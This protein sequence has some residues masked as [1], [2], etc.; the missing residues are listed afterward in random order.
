MKRRYKLMLI[1]FISFLLVIFIYHFFYKPKRIYYFMGERYNNYV[2]YDFNDI[3]QTKLKKYQY[4]HSKELPIIDEYNDAVMNNKD[5]I[6][7]YLK[8]A[9]ILVISLGTYELENY[10]EINQSIIIEY[11]NAVYK[12]FMQVSK[13]QSGSVFIINMYDDKYPLVNNK[14]KKYASE[15][16]FY[17]IDNSFISSQDKY[18]VDNKLT[19][20]Y[21]GHQKIANYILNRGI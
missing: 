18:L 6:N 19:F 10:K 12:F 11:L 16:S 15:F 7:Y 8:N 17:Y 1:I 2:T 3:L 5:N 20:T 14:L 4:E 13:L 21:K 9:N